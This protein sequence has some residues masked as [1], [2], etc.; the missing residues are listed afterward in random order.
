ME[1]RL[2]GEEKKTVVKEKQLNPEFN[3]TFELPIKVLFHPCPP[4]PSP[5]SLPPSPSHRG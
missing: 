4:R 2:S 1:V 3:Q 5:P